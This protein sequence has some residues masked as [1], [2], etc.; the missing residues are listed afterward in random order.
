MD[1]SNYGGKRATDKRSIL[2]PSP[3]GTDAATSM[4]GADGSTPRTPET[5]PYKKRLLGAMRD[6]A[7]ADASGSTGVLP[8]SAQ[9]TSVLACAACAGRHRPHTCFKKTPSKHGPSAHA[10]GARRG[11][12]LG[13]V[14]EGMCAACVGRHRPHTCAKRLA[15]ADGRRRERCAACEGRHRPHTCAKARESGE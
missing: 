5:A 6:A 9:S 11:L 4:P 14:A 10:D 3:N 15:L 1:G 12:E 7:V 2:L 13:G 8:T